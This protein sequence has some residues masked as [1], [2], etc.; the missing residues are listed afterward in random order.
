[1]IIVA[2]II[3]VVLPLCVSEGDGFDVMVF[4]VLDKNP[5]DCV[6]TKGGVDQEV[7]LVLIKIKIITNITNITN[8]TRIT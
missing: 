3:I 2:T 1:M 7:A 6:P 4:V 5:K 8:I